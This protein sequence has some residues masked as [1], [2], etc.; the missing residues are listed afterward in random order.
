MSPSESD[1]VMRLCAQTPQNTTENITEKTSGVSGLSGNGITVRTETIS[2]LNRSS[3]TRLSAEESAEQRERV[4]ARF[5]N[6]CVHCF[7]WADHVHHITPRSHGSG[8]IPDEELVPV[9]RE[10]HEL[11]HSTSPDSWRE[12]LYGWRDRAERLLNV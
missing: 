8:S 3:T 5:K 6:R 12:T 9:C 11:I 4:L 2:W 1:K 10:L 7:T